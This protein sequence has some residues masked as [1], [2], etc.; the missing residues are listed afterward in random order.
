MWCHPGSSTRQNAIYAIGPKMPK[1]QALQNVT[2]RKGSPS[3]L[4][5]DLVLFLFLNGNRTF[6]GPSFG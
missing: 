5:G 3:E 1:M 4:A 6:F 2:G